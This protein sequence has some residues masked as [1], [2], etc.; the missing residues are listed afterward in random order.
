MKKFLLLT[1]LNSGL[2]ILSCFGQNKN[3][4][5]LLT[6]IKTEKPDTLKVIHLYQLTHEYQLTGNFEKGL[7]CGED[8]LKLAGKLDFKKGTAQASNNIGNIYRLQADYPLALDFYLKALRIDEDIKNKKGIATRLGNIGNVYLY[9]SDY[10][11][12]LNYYF[13]ALKMSKELG[14]KNNIET[15]LGNIGSVYADQSDY[16]KALEY[17]FKALKM[18]EGQREKNEI[19]LGNIGAAYNQLKDYPQALDFY[20]QALKASEKAG[21]KNQIATTLGNIGS[22]YTTTGKF[23]EAEQ[24]LKKALRMNDSIGFMNDLMQSEKLLSKLYDTIGRHKEALLHFKKAVALKDT[25]FSQENK[26]QLVRKEMN[27]EFDKKEAAI[28]TEQAIK[29]LSLQR[30]R[31]E[32]KAAYVLL[33]FLALLAG[34]IIWILIQ[35]RK[36]E[37][38]KSLQEKTDTEKKKFELEGK[39]F[40]AE[41]KALRSQMNPH[42]IFNCM[43]SIQSFMTQNDS[44]SAAKFLSKFA[45]LIRAT[46]ENSDHAFIS[47]E[48]EI[49]ML[50]DYLEL[51]KL[52]FGKKFSY[53]ISIDPIIDT[54]IIEIPSMLIQP[55]IENAIIHGI[56]PRRDDDGQ[57]KIGF[58]IINNVLICKI[59]DNGVGRKKAMEIKKM[60]ELTHKSMGMSI[61]HERLELI[62]AKENIDIRADIK[63]V[64]DKNNLPIGT[65][66]EL[67]IPLRKMKLQLQI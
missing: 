67:S 16:P 19:W 40:N 11:R 36:T 48:S 52:R 7:R 62:S 31:S 22:L 44:V 38:I 33:V 12:A 39:W 5:S 51:E 9:Q 24:Y 21:N 50:E 60:T 43:A 28:K 45:R 4:D 2:L 3:I 34:A 57:I 25:L 26:K 32:K 35:R 10:T 59:S 65:T 63:D 8:A 49:K 61:L 23:K 64:E 55:Y 27:Y 42:F 17:Y 1:I 58:K 37:N 41:L 29:E 13:E 18:S 66:V 54:E 30:E 14:D 56:A 6:L 53:T 47:L 46:L 15:W 20:F